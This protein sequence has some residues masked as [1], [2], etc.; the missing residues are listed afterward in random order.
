MAYNCQSFFFLF[1][2]FSLFLF[3]FCFSYFCLF[4][5]FIAFC[6]FFHFFQ[7][8]RR[9][10]WFSDQKSIYLYFLSLFNPVFIFSSFHFFLFLLFFLPFSSLFPFSQKHKNAPLDHRRTRRTSNQCWWHIPNISSSRY[11]SQNLNTWRKLQTAR[12]CHIEVEWNF[13]RATPIDIRFR[14]CFQRWNFQHKISTL[15]TR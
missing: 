14:S 9:S 3:F 11:K 1:S 15:E 10:S 8:S 12:K 2:I 5:L 13:P 7:Y 6:R 4:S